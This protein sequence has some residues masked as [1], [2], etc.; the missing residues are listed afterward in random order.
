MS[1]HV[2]A[3]LM[4]NGGP[5]ESLGGVL[6][7]VVAE[8]G[9]SREQR[10]QRDRHLP[11]GGAADDQRWSTDER[12]YKT[13]EQARSMQ[14]ED[15]VIGP[16]VRMARRNTVG[17]KGFDLDMQTES[18]RFNDQVWNRFQEY[19]ND[20][21]ECDLSRRHTFAQKSGLYFSQAIVCGDILAVGV[22]DD[23]RIKLQEWEAHQIRTPTSRRYEPLDAASTANRIRLGV[24]LDQYRTPVAYHVAKTFSMAGVARDED[25]SRIEA[26][27]PGLGIP[28]AFHVYNA[29]RVSQSRGVSAL[30]PAFGVADYFEDINFAKLVQHLIVSCI[31]FVETSAPETG[32]TINRTQPSPGDPNDPMAMYRDMRD[33]MMRKLYPGAHFKAPPGGDLKPF[34]PTVPNPEFFQHVKLML[35]LIGI[36]LGLPLVMLL[37][38]ASETNFSGWRGAVDEAH[39]GFLDNQQMMAECFLR[40]F[41]KL[42]LAVEIRRGR[43]TPPKTVT[44]PFAH[45]WR[46]RAWGYIEPLKDANASSY[47]MRNLLASP[48]RVHGELSQEWET[49]VDHT[50]KDNAYAILQA[51]KAAQKLNDKAKEIGLKNVEIP[52]QYLLSL[53]TLDRVS[54]T[55][56]I[57]AASGDPKPA[58][59]PPAAKPKPAGAPA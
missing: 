42:W 36:N 30:Y 14:R 1:T 48:R 27:H 37:M 35:Q 25:M 4:L 32:E 19:A 46:G 11:T 17:P 29:Y 20:P 8:W 50:V 18:K 10:L 26:I 2:H 23:G 47:R 39:E 55:M 54:G 41:L 6:D 5:G 52:W 21:S 24:E 49:E 58:K 3:P 51:M 9:D 31:G 7:N 38:D 59:A 13:V 57:D 40:P 12:F 43:L 33:R 56:T 28:Q 44:D 15:A 45:V 34:S 53:P 22:D 16:S